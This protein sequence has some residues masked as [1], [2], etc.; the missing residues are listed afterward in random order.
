MIF[1]VNVAEH[2]QNIELV[3]LSSINKVSLGFLLY[4]DTGSIRDGSY[5]ISRE[6]SLEL[7]ELS[8]INEVTFFLGLSGT[9]SIIFS[10]RKQRQAT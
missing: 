5:W 2:C 1:T 7:M 9:R 8:S 6:N 10:S 3:D 4:S